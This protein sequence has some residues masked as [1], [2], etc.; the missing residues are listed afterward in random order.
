MPILRPTGMERRG[1][2]GRLWG[3]H[4]EAVCR[5]RADSGEER[6]R[7]QSVEIRGLG[8]RTAIAYIA[9][10]ADEPGY[11]LLFHLRLTVA[12]GSARQDLDFAVPFDIAHPD[13]TRPRCGQWWC[14]RRV[15]VM[16]ALG[17]AAGHRLWRQQR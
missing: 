14:R 11:D 12:A 13:R 6:E 5:V 1:L 9:H 17:Q 7:Y 15:D 4:T 2:P 3:Y 16:P 8:V 10:P